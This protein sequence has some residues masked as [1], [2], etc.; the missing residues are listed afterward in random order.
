MTS[1]AAKNNILMRCPMGQFL[2]TI[3]EV[4]RSRAN[5]I[6]CTI[7]RNANF[8]FYLFPLNFTPFMAIYCNKADLN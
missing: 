8:P 6:S 3:R 1:N 5:Q 7:I 4:S 2:V